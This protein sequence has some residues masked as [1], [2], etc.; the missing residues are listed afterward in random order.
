M[1]ERHLAVKDGERKMTGNE[2]LVDE[3]CSRKYD[4]R[5]AD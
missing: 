1:P 3:N 4:G 5:G 2:A